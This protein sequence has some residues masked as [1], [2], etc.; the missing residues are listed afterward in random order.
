MMMKTKRLLEEADF[1]AKKLHELE[2]LVRE[3][4]GYKL[5]FKRKINDAAKVVAEL[6]AFANSS[7]GVLLVGVNDDKQIP[8]VK[9]PEDESYTLQS[10]IAKHCKPQ[11]K[12][13]ESVIQ[14]APN[15]FVLQ[16]NIAESRRKP[17]LFITEEG[18]KK[19]YVRH[20]DKTVQA[21]I[22]MR[23]VIKRKRSKRN[24]Q[25]K[26]GEHEEALMKYLQQHPSISFAEYLD[27]TK[28][29]RFYAS[30]RLVTLVLANVLEITPTERG[31]R[32]SLHSSF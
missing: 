7:G 1:D 8:G 14:V 11:L 32:Y 16:Y 4:E 30:K 29:K 22:E 15:R 27:L 13:R 26:Y 25:F 21:S 19:V 3:G 6:C 31:D 28:Q 24:I 18:L 10:A 12:F 2:A 20:E 23:E 9:F 17:Q 5:E